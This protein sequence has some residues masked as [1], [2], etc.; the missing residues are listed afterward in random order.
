MNFRSLLLTLTAAA[1]AAIAVLNWNT[2]AT[3]VPVS[4]G[5]VT[6]DAPLGIVMLA[7]TALLAAFALAYV[8][9]LQGSVLIETRRHG[10]EMQVQ[11][12]LADK[13]EASRFTEMK[14]FLQAQSQQTH[15][16]LMERI[17]TLESRVLARANESD[18]STAAYWGQLENQLHMPRRVLE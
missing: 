7:L 1:I 4:L 12:E 17:E 8:L 2:L 18:N 6:V 14:I 9:W 13:A 11:R 10:K 5:V 16:A 3:S 15:S